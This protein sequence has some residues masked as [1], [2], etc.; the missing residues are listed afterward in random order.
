MIV[1][2][3]VKISDGLAMVIRGEKLTD[4]IILVGANY[5][6]SNA[7]HG[8][9]FTRKQNLHAWSLPKGNSLGF[10]TISSGG[11]HCSAGRHLQLK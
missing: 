11:L 8:A 9:Y 2:L 7:R 10:S 6:L 3:V 4:I 5:T 1:I